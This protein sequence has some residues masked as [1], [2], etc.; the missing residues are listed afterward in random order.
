MSFLSGINTSVA[1]FMTSQLLHEFVMF[2]ASLGSAM[3]KGLENRVKGKVV[4]LLATEAL[5]GRGGIAP[6][7]S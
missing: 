1:R 6:T 5:G 4:L 3:R 2:H 7:L